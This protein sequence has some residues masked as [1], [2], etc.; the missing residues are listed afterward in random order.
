MRSSFTLLSILAAFASAVDLD[1]GK[2]TFNAYYDTT[3]SEIVIDTT[4][5]DLSWFG[6]L[7]GSSSMTNT[8][9]IVFFGNGASSIA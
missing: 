9:A 2:Y 6:V 4:Q 1:C 5:P 7:L 8:E 3:T